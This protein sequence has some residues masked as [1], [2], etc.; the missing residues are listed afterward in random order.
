MNDSTTYFVSAQRDVLITGKFFNGSTARNSCNRENIS[1]FSE[2][3]RRRLFSYL[4]NSV[5]EYRCFITLTYPP[6]YGLSGLLCKTELKNFLERLKR[7]QTKRTNRQIGHDGKTWSVMWFQEWQK[8]GRLHFH[9][10]ATH[11]FP[12]EWLSRAWF[13][14]VGSGNNSHLNAGTQIKRLR[15]GRAGMSK[16]ASKY[17]SKSSQKV[18]PKDFGWAG[19]F[20][21]VWGNSFTVA[22][23]IAYT[24]QQLEN[25]KAKSVIKALNM[26]IKD[27]ID[28][29]KL[30]LVAGNDEKNAFK[31]YKYSR[32]DLSPVIRGNIALYEQMFILL[33][34]RVIDV[35]DPNNV[36]NS[37]SGNRMTKPE[38][39][40]DYCD[41][42]STEE[43]HAD[44]MYRTP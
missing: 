21:G 20:W 36:L 41:T 10:C 37:D 35:F 22:A 42:L 33:K 3:S 1:C 15:G 5:A 14:I 13:D 16:Y 8:N 43:Q 19:R 34:H 31:V 12:K 25:P 39:I 24:K 4:R 2:R 6:G 18:I 11:D 7:L 26:Y 28:A 40:L 44:R 32:P 17:C 30:C 9:L 38:A 29:K 23:A 27:L